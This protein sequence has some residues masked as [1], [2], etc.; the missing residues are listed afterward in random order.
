MA[1]KSTFDKNQQN[2][3]CDLRNED[4]IIATVDKVMAQSDQL[5]ILV[6]CAGI[7]R[8]APNWELPTEEFDKII[9]TNLRGTFLFCKYVVP[10]DIA[11]MVSPKP[12]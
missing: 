10:E 3:K 4:D 5:D 1:K 6:N 12:K 8:V 11:H 7:A 2:E 9:A